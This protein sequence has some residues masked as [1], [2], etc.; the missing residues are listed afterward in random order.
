[1]SPAATG[2]GKDPASEHL[3]VQKE[4]LAARE[5]FGLFGEELSSDQRVRGLLAS[6][7]AEVELSWELLNEMDAVPVCAECAKDNPGDCC[8]ATAG[9]WQNRRI[10]FI[11]LLM[12]VTL[13][14]KPFDR[15]ACFFVGPQG[16]L[17]K[18]REAFCI[19]F[20]CPLLEEHMAPEDL[21]H[22]LRQAGKEISLGF[23]LEKTIL[24]RLPR[25]AA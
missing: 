18:A 17:L 23:E 24:A 3:F 6:Y 2:S 16:C 1:M 7:L 13:P 8:S 15:E 22:F 25:G 11:N 19:N 14:E 5:A 9:T 10:L 20:F 21:S 12:G 4:I